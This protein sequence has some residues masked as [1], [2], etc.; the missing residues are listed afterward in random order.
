MEAAGF[1]VLGGLLEFL[2]GAVED[3]ALR[4]DDT[5]ARSKKLLQL[6]PGQFLGPN[7][8]VSDDRYTRVQRITDFI[9]GMTDSYAMTFYRKLTGIQFMGG[10][11]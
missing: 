2:V 3:S 7:R 4:R 9:A 10:I 8:V 6:I 11:R 5:S 1:E